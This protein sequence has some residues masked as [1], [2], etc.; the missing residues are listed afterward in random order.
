MLYVKLLIKARK[1]RE[2]N[3][4]LMNIPSGIDYEPDF[5]IIHYVVAQ[6]L[7]LFIKFHYNS[8]I[9]HLSK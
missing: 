9:K 4:V 2:L 1:L 3:K 6:L 7:V 5:F 8:K